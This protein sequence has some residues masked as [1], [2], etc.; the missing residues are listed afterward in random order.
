MMLSTCVMFLAVSSVGALR[1]KP[2][3]EAD[4]Q[5]AGAGGFGEVDWGNHF[6]TSKDFE[7]T[8]VHHKDDPD[9]V[10]NLL[11]A[12]V[13]IPSNPYYRVSDVMCNK[14]HGVG[15]CIQ[16][17]LEDADYKGTILNTYL[18]RRNK[19]E[20]GIE[21]LKE[22]ID[23]GN[24]SVSKAQSTDIVV[25][26]R[27][28]DRA[29]MDPL[30]D[31]RTLMQHDAC[32]NAKRIVVVTAKAFQTCAPGEPCEDKHQQKKFG[33]TDK[34]LGENDAKFIKMFKGLSTL[35][36]DV[37]V[38]SH[39]NIDQDIAFM[40]AA[41]CF[42]RTIGGFSHGIMSPLVEMAGG[43]VQPGPFKHGHFKGHW[44]KDNCKF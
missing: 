29:P 21:L 13:T 8:A 26:I 31:V 15:T 9:D 39:M 2:A 44:Q 10:S 40:S 33:M 7:S 42:V 24:W 20:K 36:L 3:S 32:K 4:F 28:G 23:E 5:P 6:R 41:K 11:Q 35:G 43:V 22:I 34:V 27:A 38:Q 37:A 1:F 18:Q 16:H 17:V 25:H 14:G 12:V 30:A 19:K